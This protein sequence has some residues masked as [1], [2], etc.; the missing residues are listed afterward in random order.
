[1]RVDQP[2]LLRIGQA[3]VI[4]ERDEAR[5]DAVDGD[6]AAGELLRQRLDMPISPA[7]DAA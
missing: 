4:G 3:S 7:L 6:A 2:V 5:R 1:M